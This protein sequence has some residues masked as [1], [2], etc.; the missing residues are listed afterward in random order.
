MAESGLAFNSGRAVPVKLE[1]DI[2]VLE[3]VGSTAILRQY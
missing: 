3:A 2:D 1:V